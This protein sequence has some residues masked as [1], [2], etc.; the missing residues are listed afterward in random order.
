MDN[1][2]YRAPIQ[3]SYLRCAAELDFPEAAAFEVNI[4]EDKKTLVSEAIS[5]FKHHVNYKGENDV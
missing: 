1:F 2:Q 3:K 5:G 4:C